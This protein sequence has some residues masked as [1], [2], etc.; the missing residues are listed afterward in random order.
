MK[1]SKIEW[2]DH[3]FNPWVGCTKVSTGCANCY[4][5][6]T[7]FTRAKRKQGIEL[8]G[9][10]KP[11]HRTSAALWNQPL[12]WNKTPW[13]CD[14]CGDFFD[15][16]TSPSCHCPQCDLTYLRRSRVFSAS[17]ADWLD[18]EAPIEWLADFLKLI[19]DTPN[20][21]W[22]LLTKRPEN[23]RSR[24]ELVQAH[25]ID[26]TNGNPPYD[27]PHNMA[28]LWCR[29]EAPKNVWLGTTVEN[30]EMADKRIP[31]LAEI[32]A[33]IRFLSVEPMLGHIEISKFLKFNYWVI[34]GGESGKNARPMN[35][36]WARSLRNQ[37]QAAGVP[38][39]FKQWG[40]WVRDADLNGFAERSMIVP[41]GDGDYTNFRRMYK[42]GKKKAGRLLD[43]KEWNQF[44]A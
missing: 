7:T 35:P 28:M 16:N 15:K 11:R 10:G 6:V 23:W 5:E 44:P 36:D 38:F 1:N 32:P 4:A 14:R 26:K 42:V 9:K 39:F 18:E 33:N 8:W 19:H 27:S 24:M 31:L 34:C 13:I 29:G 37:C 25:L 3:T 30:Q 40:E 43:K 17:L 12:L 2:T 22:L 41:F 20:L 21:N